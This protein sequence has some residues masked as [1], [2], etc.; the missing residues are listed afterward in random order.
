MLERKYGLIQEGNTALCERKKRYNAEGNRPRR[1]E[2]SKDTKG[3]LTFA[4][5]SGACISCW[6]CVQRVGSVCLADMTGESQLV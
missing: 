1:Q 3:S 5:T 2:K 6:S 4:G